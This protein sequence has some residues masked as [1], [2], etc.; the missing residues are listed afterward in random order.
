V[1]DGADEISPHL[2]LIKGLGGA[3]VREKIVA[4]SASRVV[5][6]ADPSKLTHRLGAHGPLPIAV[7][8]FGWES[9]LAAL[10]ALGAEPSL[11]L[12]HAGAPY[13]TD[14]GLVVIDAR[15][16]GGIDDPIALEQA[17]ESRPGVAATG[18]F[19]G[20]AESALIGDEHGVW[21]YQR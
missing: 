20:I 21:D 14:D 13:V 3:L 18:L 17:L 7:V 4:R 5:V 1:V 11:R 2:D 10:R 8:R 15:F 6:V 16:A 19:L 9:N 12:D